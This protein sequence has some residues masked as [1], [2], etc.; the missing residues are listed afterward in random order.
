MSTFQTQLQTQI[1]TDDNL[2]DKLSD[3]SKNR[4]EDAGL[5]DLL[6]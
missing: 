3:P 1:Q 6:Q 2:Y 5:V 4:K